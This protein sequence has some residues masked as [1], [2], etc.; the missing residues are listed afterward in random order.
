MI[1]LLAV[2]AFFEITCDNYRLTIWI[3][4]LVRHCCTFGSSPVLAP[5]FVTQRYVHERGSLSSVSVA[6]RDKERGEN[7]TSLDPAGYPKLL[8]A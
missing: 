7:W 3:V 1:A 8:G 5:F 6:L 2:I 4:F